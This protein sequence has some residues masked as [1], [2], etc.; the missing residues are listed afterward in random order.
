MSAYA[1]F[2][3]NTIR[4]T[5]QRMKLQV[6]RSIH[7]GQR[8]AT[9]KQ[10]GNVEMMR[11]I[12]ARIRMNEGPVSIADYMRDILTSP[13]AGYYMHKDVFGSKGDFITSP[14]ISQMFGELL[15]VWCAAEWQACGEPGELQVVEMGPGRGTLAEDMLRAFSQLSS[16]IPTLIS[17]ISLHLVEVSPAL[18]K[19]QAERLCENSYTESDKAYY[20]FGKSKYGPDVYWYKHLADVPRQTS[21]FIAHEFFDALP[22]HKF[23]KS[24]GKWYEVMV[25]I[26]DSKL[27][28]S[29]LQL[30]Q[31]RRPYQEVLLQHALSA[32][33]EREHVEVCPEGG[34][35][36]QELANRIAIDGGF[37]LIAD[38]GH[39][40]EKEDTFRAFRSHK[41]VDPLDEP[42]TADLT[43]DV[44]FSYLRRMIGDRCAM[45]G[46]ATQQSFL[47]NMG[48]Q[49]RIKA[50][51]LKATD[52]QRKDL[53]S[54]YYML[55]EPEQMGE[56]FKFLSLSR[57]RPEAYTPAG[58][59]W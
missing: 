38:Y 42:G 27:V 47:N 9:S 2:F 33:D 13:A 11:H 8:C 41:Q 1:A 31:A 22:I 43:A 55:T 17:S 59:V 5:N 16:Q 4:H 45:Y 49:Y 29:G 35:L 24:A 44:D 18:S 15:G 28:D 36:V 26:A 52:E 21:A 40:G 12:K 46:P 20:K 48:I 14:E 37:G 10:S 57:H 25:D 23:Q 56:R 32:G 53:N 54:S 7:T 50:L 58:F 39:E 3:R 6:S 30:V 19:I 51:W 34:V